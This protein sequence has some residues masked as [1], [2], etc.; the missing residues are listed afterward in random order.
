MDWMIETYLP[1]KKDRETPLASPLHYL[2]DD[3]LAQFPPTTMILSAVDPLLDEGIA[4]GHRLQKVGVDTAIIKAEGQMHAFVLI[5]PIR[6]SAAAKA[7]IELA[8]SK[9][10]QAFPPKQL[11]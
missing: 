4:F 9:M 11:L 5:K 7:M 2:A 10:R 3:V 6:Q 1:N 8:A